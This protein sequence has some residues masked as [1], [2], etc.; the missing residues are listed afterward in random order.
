MIAKE[1]KEALL[2][3][4]LKEMQKKNWEIHRR[5][6]V[7]VN[8]KFCMWNLS[9][10][11]ALPDPKLSSERAAADEWLA[12]ERFFCSNSF[13]CSLLLSFLYASVLG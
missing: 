2:D 6:A 5:H 12:C 3:R 11:S 1:A 4:K 7:R 13:Q 9:C 8:L 10:L